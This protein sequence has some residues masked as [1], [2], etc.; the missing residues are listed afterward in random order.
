MN[1]ELGSLRNDIDNI[2]L[3]TNMTDQD[4][5]S[6]VLDNLPEECDVVLGG[7]ESRLMLSD[8]DQN[9]LTIEDIQN[10][11]KNQAE[12]IN[13]RVAEKDNEKEGVTL[14]A[15][16]KQYK[17]LVKNVGNMVTREYLFQKSKKMKARRRGKNQLFVSSLGK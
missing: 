7:M 1:Y 12:Q 11:L 16:M 13:G 5:M 17:E 10:K 4:L 6:R 3:S 15:F 9:K 14:K 8:S 2:S